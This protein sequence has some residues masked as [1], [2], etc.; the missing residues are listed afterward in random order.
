MTAQLTVAAISVYQRR[1]S[2][3]KGW[4]CAHRVRHG[5]LSC[6]EWVKRAVARHGVR[7]GVL[8]ARRRFARCRQAAREGRE[9]ARWEEGQ[10]EQEQW[11]RQKQRQQRDYSCFA[12]PVPL[13]CCWFP[14]DAGWFLASCADLGGA[15]SCVDFAGCG[16][17]P[18][19]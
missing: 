19:V 10:G 14:L 5:G 7:T 8:L 15:L 3:R 16:C 4:Q 18:F 9:E 12:E 6:S 11:E 1:I 17:L 13:D 2:P